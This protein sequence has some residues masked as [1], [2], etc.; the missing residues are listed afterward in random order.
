MKK[1]RIKKTQKKVI[2][3]LF[4][5][6]YKALVIIAGAL[7]AAFIVN[8]FLITVVRIV[9]DSMQPTLYENNWFLV[10]RIAYINSEPEY[11]DIIIFKKQDVTGGVI[12]KRVIGTP[13]DTVEIKNGF[14]YINGKLTEDEFSAASER[15]N[16]DKIIVNEDSYFVLGDNRNSSSDSRIWDNPFVNRDEIIGKICFKLFPKIKNVT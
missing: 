4:K 2:K 11:G 1:Q 7:L 3:Q 16:F 15:D 12:V 6:D 8:S 13:N 9:G 10:D 5:G 14:V